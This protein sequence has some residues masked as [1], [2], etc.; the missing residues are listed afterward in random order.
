[1]DNIVTS[2]LRLI[3]ESMK[4][5]EQEY[6]LSE[7][8]IESV[9]AYA[10]KGKM[11]PILC[12]TVLKHSKDKELPLLKEWK[13]KTMAL[14]MKQYG[15]YAAL[16]KLLSQAK[17]EGIQF[18]VFKGS[19]LADLYPQYVFRISTDTDLYVY[20]KDREKASKLLERMGYEYLKDHSNPM[21]LVYYNRKEKHCVELHFCL[22]E[23]Y[24]GEQMD[25]LRALRLDVE[26]RLVQLNICGGMQVTTLGFTEHLIY[27]IFHIVKHFVL[28]GVGI[29]YVV[30]IV[31]YVNRYAEKID[32]EEFWEKISKLGY[33]KFC[34]GIFSIGIQYFDM[35]PQYMCG[36]EILQGR[37]LEVLVMDFVNEGKIIQEEK[38]A[39]WQILGI[40]TPYL[41]GKQGYEMSKW[42]RNMKTMFPS[43]NSLSEDYQYAKNHKVLLPIAWIHRGINFGKKRIFKRK[44]WYSMGEKLEIVNYRLMLMEELALIRKEESAKCNRKK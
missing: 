19:V 2:Y 3:G 28:Q 22:W 16:R 10:V 31:L 30:D 12:N 25:V 14:V 4:Q 11:F 41:E 35:D 39:G 5:E 34:E 37:V 33:D 26:E 44:D 43:R 15:V 13:G 6:F 21:V 38:T 36:R 27:Q 7:K 1:M 32:W 20:K 42:K 29:R 17:E 24:E 23:D 9:Y 40:M 18:I 8:E